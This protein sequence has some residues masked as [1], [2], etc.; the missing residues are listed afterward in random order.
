M[1]SLEIKFQ[2]FWSIDLAGRKSYTKGKQINWD[3]EVGA[4]T[5]DK[6]VNSVSNEVECGE[7][8]RATMWFFIRDWVRM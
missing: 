4:L 8:Q 3:V 7:N 1:F 5:V 2:A 6:L